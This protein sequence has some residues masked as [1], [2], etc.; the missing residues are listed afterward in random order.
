MVSG[1]RMVAGISMSYP[2]QL[3]LMRLPSLKLHGCLCTADATV[4]I[5][6]LFGTQVRQE[7]ARDLARCDERVA[8]IHLVARTA[9][10]H[11]QASLGI[12]EELGAAV[13]AVLYVPACAVPH[14]VPVVLLDRTATG[15]AVGG[16]YHE[17]TGGA[18]PAPVRLGGEGHL[19][20]A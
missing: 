17:G 4:G 20:L 12:G 10:A 5:R 13:C 2:T 8:A 6:Q 11:G 18:I 9:Q 16:K 7:R 15:H 14:R 1:L 3:R 19:V